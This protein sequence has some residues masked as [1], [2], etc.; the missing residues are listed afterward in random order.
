MTRRDFL[1]TTLSALIGITVGATL[2]KFVV[3]WLNHSS[4]NNDSIGIYSRIVDDRTMAVLISN[5][6]DE[7]I[8]LNKIYLDSRLS[9][10][11]LGSYIPPSLVLV[12]TSKQNQQS[13]SFDY[14]EEGKIEITGNLVLT[15]KPKERD[16]FH[17]V[18]QEPKLK[19]IKVTNI[20]LGLI[21]GRRLSVDGEF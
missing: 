4:I 7:V 13:T 3:P 9:N 15:L 20:D 17:L 6:S 14:K 5:N 16:V 11:K 2:D 1:L 21:D 18:F 10:K 12:I 19:D 8:D